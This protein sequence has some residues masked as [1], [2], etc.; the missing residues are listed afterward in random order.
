MS[1]SALQGMPLPDR[2]ERRIPIESL[3]MPFLGSR[4]PDSSL[5]QYLVQDLSLHGAKI[6]LPKWVLKREHLQIGDFIDLHLPIIF[7]DGVFEA[8]EI[9]WDK[10]DQEI[11]A[12]AYGVRIKERAPLYYPVSISFEG[13]SV[14]IDLTAFNASENIMDRVLK[15]SILLKKGILIYLKHLKPMT[16]R[17]LDAEASELAQIRDFFFNDTGGSVQANIEKLK[18]VRE[19]FNETACSMHKMATCFN[20]EDLRITMEP[21]I[22]PDVWN[23][24]FEQENM[25]QYI[26]AIAQLERRLLYNYN[27]IVMLY[28]S[29]IS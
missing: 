29:S 2:I 23:A 27:T 21:E 8:G 22:V 16:A 18:R 15:D 19:S 10:Y 28:M 7:E 24:A 4:V 14:G 20:L 11:D 12:Q 6:V 5:F 1:E 13:Q 9:V 3:V 17:M 25:S 26:G